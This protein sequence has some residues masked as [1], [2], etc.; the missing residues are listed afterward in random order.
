MR[1]MFYNDINKIFNV[2]LEDDLAC[3]CFGFGFGR[4]VEFDDEV[5]SK[6]SEFSSVEWHG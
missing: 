2:E 3:F 1:E 4:F 5:L 6:F